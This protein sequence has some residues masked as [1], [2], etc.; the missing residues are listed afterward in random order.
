MR[1]NIR[2]IAMTSAAAMGDHAGGTM[3]A[4]AP[5]GHRVKGPCVNDPLKKL[6]WDDLRVVKAIGELGSLSAAAAQIGVNASTVFRRLGEIEKL[7]E[8]SLFE[9][10]RQGYV[11]TPV[12]AELVALA[13]RL[14]IDIVAVTR[15]LAGLDQELAGALRIATSDGLATFLLMPVIA[16]FTRLHPA[17]RIE[18][19][20]GNDALNL[21]RGETDIAV[22]ATDNPPE[23]MVGR[24]IA[25]IGWAPYGRRSDFAGGPPGPERSGPDRLADHMWASFCDEL[26]GLKVTR[27]I[28]TTVP[29]ERI[30][31]R[32]NSVQG[33]AAA[34]SAGVGVGYLPCMTGDMIPDLVRIGPADPALADALWLLTHPD[35][36]KSGRVHTF[37]EYC[38]TMLARRR[39]FIEGRSSP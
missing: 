33:M 39:S 26:A 14:E 4:P 21:A 10:R 36:R 24:R 23:T 17:V 9:R 11:A 29:P 25:D 5:A 32:T 7:L 3:I 19:V 12:G 31:F 35:L 34:I 27:L 6:C 28:D 20:I 37:L 18:M 8:L 16:G 1:S 13:Q 15:R 22:R 2:Q 38:A 30:V